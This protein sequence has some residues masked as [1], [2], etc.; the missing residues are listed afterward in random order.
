MKINRVEV[1][2]INN[3]KLNQSN[4]NSRQSFQG[5]VNGNYYKDEV[6]QEAKKALNNPNWKEKFLA[7]KKTLGE[8][9]STW[10]EREGSSDLTSRVLMGIFT[11]GISEVTWGLANRAM[12]VSDN[13]EID[14][15]IEEVENCIDDLGGGVR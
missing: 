6:I 2:G 14:L 10:H 3:H 8:T 1:V 9:L 13:R 11:L 7:R 15:F 4:K 12:D 5:F